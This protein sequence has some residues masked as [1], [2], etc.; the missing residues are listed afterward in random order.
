MKVKGTNVAA[1]TNYDGK[2]SISAGQNAVLVFSALGYGTQ[3]VTA[4]G[5][6]VNVKLQP[7]STKLDD[8]VVTAG[9][10]EKQR[11][12]LG[13]GVEEI[14]GASVKNSGESNIIS[15]LSAKVSGV[16]VTNSSGASG[17]ASYIRI[18]GNATFTSSDN[19]PLIVVDGVPID[20]SMTNTEDLRSGVAYSNRAMDLN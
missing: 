10:V 17:A 16:Q 18:R 7:Q 12:A 8:I 15:G 14:K 11:R 6:V 3:E 13:F 1:V 19:Q 5:N 4:S 20:N 2:Y 9:G